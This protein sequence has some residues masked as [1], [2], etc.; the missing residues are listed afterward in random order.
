MGRLI[1]FNFS[2]MLY[3]SCSSQFALLLQGEP[4]FFVCD[5][6]LLSE[7][8]HA[9]HASTCFNV[10]NESVDYLLSINVQGWS[11]HLHFNNPCMLE[12][13]L[14]STVRNES[15]DS[16]LSVDGGG[17]STSPR[18]NDPCVFETGLRLVLNGAAGARG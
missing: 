2:H 6:F 3:F 15:V 5:A 10:R 18:F 14:A 12:T 9:I 17:R 16:L 4:I 13:G 1:I 8:V 7:R 11:T